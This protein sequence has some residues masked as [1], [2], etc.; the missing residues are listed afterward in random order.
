M[1]AYEYTLINNSNLTFYILFN[2]TLKKAQF[3][4]ILLSFY[5]H[6]KSKLGCTISHGI[7]SVKEVTPLMSPQK[8][9]HITCGLIY[10]NKVT[11]GG[12]SFSKINICMGAISKHFKE[13]ASKI[14]HYIRPEGRYGQ[15]L[16]NPLSIFGHVQ[17]QHFFVIQLLLV[18]QNGGFPQH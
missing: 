15:D 12:S 2:V 13:V 8:N 1:N 9:C 7:F 4:I 17:Y 10:K 18:A 11:V 3:C 6:G 14:T 16:K 5:I